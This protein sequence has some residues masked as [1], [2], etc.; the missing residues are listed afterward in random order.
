M[1]EQ[2]GAFESAD[3]G[4][5]NLTG[6]L[7]FESVPMLYREMERRLPSAGPVTVIDLSSVTTVDSAGLALLLEWQSRQLQRGRELTMHNAPENLQR[8]AELC[9]A[10]DM[11]KLSGRAGAP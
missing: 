6:E 9:E 3:D 10:V 11:L 8:L 4:T 7:T 1:N 2:R 5:V